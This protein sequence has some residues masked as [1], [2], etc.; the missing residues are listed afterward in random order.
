[1][2]HE[3]L[4]FKINKTSTET[5]SFRNLQGYYILDMDFVK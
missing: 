4:H 5:E 3:K 2:P 1:M